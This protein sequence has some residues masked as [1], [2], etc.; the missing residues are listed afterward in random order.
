MRQSGAILLQLLVEK[1][2]G[3]CRA[4]S[5]CKLCLLVEQGEVPNANVAQSAMIELHSNSNCFVYEFV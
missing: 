3:A 1:I 4:R 5:S 2:A